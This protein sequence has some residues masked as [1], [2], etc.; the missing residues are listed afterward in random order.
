MAT[1]GRFEGLPLS[2]VSVI[3]SLVS[4]TDI[5]SF[6]MCSKWCN[7]HAKKKLIKED[8][9]E[10]VLLD[11]ST[12]RSRVNRRSYNDETI[13]EDIKKCRY[14]LD[15][16]INLDTDDLEGVY[17]QLRDLN[18]QVDSRNL[19]LEYE[20]NLANSELDDMDNHDSTMM[21]E[22]SIYDLEL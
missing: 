15:R 13:K 16:M 3:L 19:V 11:V 20:E 6:G 2:I 12:I 5:H 10:S 4:K 17:G 9:V 1:T 18:D 8:S 7:I 22:E 14:R 21:E